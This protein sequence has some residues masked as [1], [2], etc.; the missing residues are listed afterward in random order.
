MGL[1]NARIVLQM[2]RLV[3]LMVDVWGG[4]DWLDFGAF[5]QT[6]LDYFTEQTTARGD[7]PHVI[8]EGYEDYENFLRAGSAEDFAKAG[9][10]DQLPWWHKMIEHPAY[11]GFWQEQALDKT[12]AVQ[13]LKVPTMW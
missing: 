9:G 6:N 3:I 4:D 8:R 1:V 12:M 2:V 10:L 13:P 7:G 5:R 11:D